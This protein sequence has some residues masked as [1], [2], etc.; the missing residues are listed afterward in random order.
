MED[1][2]QWFVPHTLM[3]TVEVCTFWKRGCPQG[4]R[5]GLSEL[6]L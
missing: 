5:R 4:S 1:T 3:Q 2:A 6:A